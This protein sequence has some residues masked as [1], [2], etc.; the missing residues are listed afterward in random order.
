MRT[1][2]PSTMRFHQHDGNPLDLKSTGCASCPSCLD[3]FPVVSNPHHTSTCRL[4][5]QTTEPPDTG[6]IPLSFRSCKM[7]CFCD[8]KMDQGFFQVSSFPLTRQSPRHMLP[9]RGPCLARHTWTSA[10]GSPAAD[11]PPTRRRP[12]S[13][14][15]P[16]AMPPRRSPRLVEDLDLHCNRPASQGNSSPAKSS[17]P[18]KA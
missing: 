6:M 3:V 4:C 5:P 2:H 7:R 16:E 14:A 15:G 10:D 1:S 11:S 9:K 8:S 18:V 12:A 13:T 17:A